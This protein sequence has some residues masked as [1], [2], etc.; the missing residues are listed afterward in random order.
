MDENC[1][2]LRAAAHNNEV[3][4]VMCGSIVYVLICELIVVSL[5]IAIVSGV[6]SACF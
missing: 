4:I 6:I 2:R 1:N 5:V 3:F